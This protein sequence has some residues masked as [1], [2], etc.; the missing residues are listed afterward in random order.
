MSVRDFGIAER[1]EIARI[2][3]NL[4][5]MAV[6]VNDSRCEP[7]LLTDLAAVELLPAV[8]QLDQAIRAH[9]RAD[10]EQGVAYSMLF[11]LNLGGDQ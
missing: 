6:T 9:A 2:L 4:A 11:D 10:Y 1:L 7:D 8:R 3:S 5:A